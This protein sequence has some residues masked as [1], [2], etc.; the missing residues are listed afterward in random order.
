M[1]A[2]NTPVGSNVVV[3][4]VVGL[5]TPVTLTFDDITTAGTT[6]VTADPT[7]APVPTGFEL[8]GSVSCF[9]I[10]TTATTSGNIE[11]CVEYDEGLITG[12]ESAI[13]LLHFDT[14]LDPDDYADV[15]DYVDEVNNI[16]CGTVTHFSDFALATP[17]PTGIL[18]GAGP[19][20][21]ALRQNVPN[22]FN[23]ATTIEYDVPRGGADVTIAVFDVAGRL[24]RT[25]VDGFVAEGPQEVTWDGR[26]DAGRPLPSGLYFYRMTAAGFAET[27]KMVLMK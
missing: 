6:T 19:V 1:Q 26:N 25:L 22:P 7:C 13:R 11:V 5:G 27:R 8:A 2:F 4:P 20:T 16:V 21:F 18:P 14:D 17:V 9:Q 3:E 12:P 15:T 23:P 10:A 24:A